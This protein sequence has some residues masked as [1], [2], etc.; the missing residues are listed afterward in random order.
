[1]KERLDVI[2]VKKGFFESRERAKRA[3]MS[4]IVYVDAS[5]RREGWEPL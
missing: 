5:E 4:G 1:M 3:V 2:L